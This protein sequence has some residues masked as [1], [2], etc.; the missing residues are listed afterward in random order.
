[1]NNNVQGTRLLADAADHAGVEKFVMIST[2]KAVRPTNIMGTTKRIAELYTQSLNKTSKTSFVT[3][4]F[5]NVL[6]SN[7]SVIPTFKEQIAKGGPV[8]VTHP[9]VTRFFMTI[10]EST[11]LVLQ[12]GSMGLGG[13][14]YL[15]D[16]G[17]AVKI[18]S[19]AEE[20]IR[21]SGLQPHEDIEIVYTGLRSGEKLY[22]ELLLDDEGAL[23]TPH[24]QIC[25][26][27]SVTPP[28]EELVVM[29]ELLVADAKAR[30]LPGLKEKLQRLVPEYTPVE[31][32]PLAKVIPHPATAM[33]Q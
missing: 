16:M 25:I 29:I 6:G 31:N 22:E 9:E 4:R 2:D 13:E 8:T 28:H 11:Q 18:Q 3:T 14:I 32:K 26:A 5:G 10:P 17:E 23:P 1:V 33:H 20:L 12:A 30:N 27:Q 15:F 21:L 7:G 24:N 19:L